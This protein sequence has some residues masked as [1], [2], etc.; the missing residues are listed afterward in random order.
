MWTRYT[1][2]FTRVCDDESPHLITHVATTP[3]S[4]TDDAVTEPIHQDLQQHDLAPAYHL[5]D[6]GYITARLL[7]TITQAFGVEL[8]GPSKVDVR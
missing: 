8:I 3:A 2:H 5:L 1:V 4:T 7:A 6:S